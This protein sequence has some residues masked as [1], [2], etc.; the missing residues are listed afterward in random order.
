MTY[1]KF[2]KNNK[3]SWMQTATQIMTVLSYGLIVGIFI[4]VHQI[5]R[6]LADQKVV[7]S[8]GDIVVKLKDQELIDQANNLTSKDYKQISCLAK[9]M[10]FEARS[11]SD[12]GIEAVGFVTLNRV[13][14]GQFPNT[15]CG[16]VYDAKFDADTNGKK[17]LKYDC[18][19][20]WYCDNIDDKIRD[21]DS[22]NHIYGIAYNLYLNYQSMDDVTK[23]AMYYHNTTVHPAWDKTFVKTIKIE[24]HIFFKPK[25]L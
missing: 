16:V 3:S 18:Q 23:G 5:K 7:L 19:F 25:G 12:E 4:D 13:D 20:T 17:P 9:N 11:Q 14:S 15:I 24:D 21:R 10:Y 22:W 6:E 8:N 1:T 2:S